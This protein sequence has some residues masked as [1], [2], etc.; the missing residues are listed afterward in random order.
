MAVT[1]PQMRRW[2]SV[3]GRHGLLL[4]EVH[5]LTVVDTAQFMTEA[6]SLHFDAL[7]SWSG[8]MLAPAPHWH[9]ALGHAG[10]IPDENW[11]CYPKGSPYTRITLQR[12]V[13]APCAG[14]RLAT[15]SDLPQLLELEEQWDAPF[16]RSSE[17]T[18]RQRIE[19]HP[20]G[21]FVAFAGN[22]TLL[23]AMYTQ[24]VD[25]L[26]VLRE[27]VRRTEATLHTPHGA[28]TQLLGVVARP[29]AGSLGDVL[30]SFV[31]R[32]AQLSGMQSVCAVTRCRDWTAD[33]EQSFAEHVQTGRDRGLRF[34]LNAG[35]RMCGLVAGYRPEDAANEGH[36]VLIEYCLG[37]AVDEEVRAGDQSPAVGPRN[38]RAPRSDV[39]CAPLA[40]PT[41]VREPTRRAAP[42]AWMK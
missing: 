21:Q 27:A 41:S 7:Q 42:L 35:A 12:L 24:R 32:Q 5:S 40:L 22:S 17:A 23:A 18:L 16:L 19:L 2:A 14:F 28:V 38:S 26:E 15:L 8:Q 36:G 34:H 25:S 31:L 1:Q 33:S 29:S 13:P 3:A 39:S 9:L 37:G 10:L 4:L 11:L 30:R 6:T 20:S